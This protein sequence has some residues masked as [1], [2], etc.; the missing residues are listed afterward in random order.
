MM[1]KSAR[2]KCVRLQRVSIRRSGSRRK[3]RQIDKFPGTYVSTVC[4]FSD[5]F[6]LVWEWGEYVLKGGGS[7]QVSEIDGD[8]N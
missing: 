8:R 2:M 1:G 7:K 3:V 5:V 6:K 4:I